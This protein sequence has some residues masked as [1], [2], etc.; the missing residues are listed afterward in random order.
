MTHTLSLS[1]LAA[2][3]FS[4]SGCSVNPADCDP[5]HRDAS[6]IAKTRCT[7]SGAYQVRVDAK[8]KILLDEQKANAL[9]RDLYNAVDKEKSEVR[10]ELQSKRSEYGALKRAL[11]ALLAELKTKAGDNQQIKGE[12][13]ALEQELAQLE[14][15]QS[16]TSVVQKQAQLDTLRNKVVEL[17]QGLGLRK[18]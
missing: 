12:I 10:A 3:L 14:Q 2:A 7:S 4:L 11:N 8:K 6:L 1:L 15:S 18:P 13:Q 5:T 9:F 16:N 17:E